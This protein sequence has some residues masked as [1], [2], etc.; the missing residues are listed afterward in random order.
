MSKVLISCEFFNILKFGKYRDVIMLLPQW[1]QN[2]HFKAMLLPLTLKSNT[3]IRVKPH[4][5]VKKLGFR[6]D[7]LHMIIRVLDFW[8][9]SVQCI[10]FRFE[11]VYTNLM[12]CL[13]ISFSHLNFNFDNSRSVLNTKYVT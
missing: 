5:H 2:P 9:C 11:F 7:F 1:N 4:S 12:P 10:N 3:C 8:H 6:F 13:F